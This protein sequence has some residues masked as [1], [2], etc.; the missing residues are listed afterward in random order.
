M[1]RLSCTQSAQ[2]HGLSKSGICVAG[3][4]GAVPRKDPP[5]KPIRMVLD[6]IMQ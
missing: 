6:K 4:R 5:R 1:L 3:R 2:V